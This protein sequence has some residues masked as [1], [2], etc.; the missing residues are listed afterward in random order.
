MAKPFKIH[1]THHMLFE[2]FKT[3][4]ATEW[5]L[6][7]TKFSKSPNSNLTILKQ[8]QISRDFR[9]IFHIN[10]RKFASTWPKLLEDTTSNS[11]WKT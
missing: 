6:F 10:S 4:R 7:Q 11:F 8:I 5:V 9:N 2:D 1:W 3:V